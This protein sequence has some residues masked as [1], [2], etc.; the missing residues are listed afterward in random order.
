MFIVT[1]RRSKNIW[2]RTDRRK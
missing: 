2:C 1:N